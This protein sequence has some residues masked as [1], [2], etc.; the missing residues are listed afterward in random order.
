MEMLFG[1]AIRLAVKH[2]AKRITD[3]GENQKI[4][5]AAYLELLMTLNGHPAVGFGVTYSM[6]WDPSPRY[7]IFMAF[8][9]QFRRR[10]N[11]YET[12]LI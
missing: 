6:M 3:W 4:L 5:G 2:F 8:I 9:Q 7:V 1:K 11:S 12:L 10:Q